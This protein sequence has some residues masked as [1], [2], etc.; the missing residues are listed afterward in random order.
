MYSLYVPVY[1]AVLFVNTTSCAVNRSRL[2]R[3]NP[4]GLGRA[5]IGPR[6]AMSAQ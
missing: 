2:F 5:P 4:F 6:R 1:F 3:L